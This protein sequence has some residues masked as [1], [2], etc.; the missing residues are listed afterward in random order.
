MRQSTGTRPS[1]PGSFAAPTSTSPATCV[2]SCSKPCGGRHARAVRGCG[3]HR[4]RAAVV[5]DVVAVPVRCVG[6][7]RHERRDLGVVA[8]H[9]HARGDGAVTAFRHEAGDRLVEGVHEVVCLGPAA[10]G[11]V[12][13]KPVGAHHK[14]H[15]MRGAALLTHGD[16]RGQ[17]GETHDE[18]VVV[19]VDLHGQ[20]GGARVVG[21]GI[22]GL[23]D[24]DAPGVL[25][26]DGAGAR[27]KDLLPAGG[28]VGVNELAHPGGFR[29]CG[30][31]G[32]QRNDGCGKQGEKC[33]RE[34][35]TSRHD[36][37][38]LRRERETNDPCIP[39]FLACPRM[40]S[41]SDTKV[42]HA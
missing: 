1:E 23:V 8:D 25:R 40:L 41:A 16:S 22:D 28:G 36:A 35:A 5:R 4:K 14:D 32:G 18:A 10:V 21:T 13:Q 26:R 37:P 29:A 33:V 38:I 7:E 15:V 31:S 3:S 42:A 11:D 19:H 39:A 12:L 6:A 2:A 30:G 9:G 17:R 27:A 20:A 34:R 24:P